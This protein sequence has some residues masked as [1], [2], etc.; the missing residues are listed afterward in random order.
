M[1]FPT[2]KEM[3]NDI[4]DGKRARLMEEIHELDT[5]ALAM[6][7]LDWSNPQQFLTTPAPVFKGISN[8]IGVYSIFYVNE[9]IELF[10]VGQ[11]NLADRKDRHKLIFNNQGNPVIHYRKNA[12]TSSSDSVVGRKMYTKDSDPAHWYFSYCECSKSW[13]STIEEYIVKKYAPPGNHI[14]MAVHA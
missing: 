1:F 7:N 13:A 14:R 2:F 3:V 9:S 12:M 5:V 10:Y 4:V 8:A 11:G 6:H